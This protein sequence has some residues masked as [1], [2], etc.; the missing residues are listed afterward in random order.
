MRKRI[1]FIGFAMTAMVSYLVQAGS[2]V[3][4]D[5]TKLFLQHN[6]GWKAIYDGRRLVGLVSG[7][8]IENTTASSAEIFVQ[9]TTS[10]NRA[11]FGIYGVN[12]DESTL[13][14]ID[15][16]VLNSGKIVYTFA[17]KVHGVHVHGSIVKAISNSA[18]TILSYS[19]RTAPAPYPASF[20]ADVLTETQ[21]KDVIRNDPN[22]DGIDTF[23][24]GLMVALEAADGSLKKV[25]RFGGWGGARSY[26]F[27]VDTNSGHL[28]AAINAMLG[29][30][31]A[32]QVGGWPRS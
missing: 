2:D 27:F 7:A 6:E 13:D 10:D 32:G 21:A 3:P 5:A 16:R 15:T 28:V 1:S 26:E 31:V 20:P 4:L 17:Q 24:T 30:D 9:G 18:G 14:L 12:T 22:Y 8:G 11:A 19:L 25:W 23:G 29:V